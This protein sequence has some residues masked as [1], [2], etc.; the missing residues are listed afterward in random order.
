[1]TDMKMADSRAIT[2]HALGIN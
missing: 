2:T 1:M